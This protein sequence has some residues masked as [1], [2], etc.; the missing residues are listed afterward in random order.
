M[1]EIKNAGSPATAELCL[2]PNLMKPRLR[3]AGAS[4]M[5]L[6]GLSEEDRAGT[7]ENI[8]LAYA[9]LHRRAWPHD[10]IEDLKEKAEEFGRS[11][12]RR[13]DQVEIVSGHRA[14]RA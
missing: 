11:V 5:S 1:T 9:I 4:V 6:L 7:F 8:I 12:I 13:F 10:P 2:P 14:G 3:R